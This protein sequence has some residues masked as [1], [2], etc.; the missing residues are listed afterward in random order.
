MACF[1]SRFD[2]YC[3]KARIREREAI[4]HPIKSNW[5]ANQ[6]TMTKFISSI[7]SRLHAYVKAQLC[8]ENHCS[9]H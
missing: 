1:V 2:L 4:E 9:P 8:E 6:T 5:M 7:S 3:G